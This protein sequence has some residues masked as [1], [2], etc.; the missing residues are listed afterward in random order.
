MS[1]TKP[2]STSTTQTTLQEA[3]LCVGPGIQGGQRAALVARPAPAGTG[4]R[5]VRRDFPAGRGLI[6]ARWYNVTGFELNTAIHNPYGATVTG[7]DPLLTA[8]RAYGV[9][10][11]LIEVIGPELPLLEYGPQAFIDLIESTGIARQNEPRR[12]FW[13]RQPVVVREGT[14]V[15][16]LLP[17]ADT[18]ISVELGGRNG[19]AQAV[20]ASLRLWEAPGAPPLPEPDGLPSRSIIA[21]V[22]G[23]EPATDAQVSTSMMRIGAPPPDAPWNNILMPGARKLVDCLSDLALAGAPIIGHYFGYNPSRRLNRVLLRTLFNRVDG[24]AYVS[25]GE[26][27]RL[28]TRQTTGRSRKRK[29]A[30]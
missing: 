27:G 14:D 16:M 13:I 8:L 7:I 4:I 17:A 23:H 12:A 26:A 20:I 30:S 22:G 3:L 18:R 29:D 2:Q 9:D 6:S 11:A 15:A 28:I 5:F 24:W 21:R 25:V 10:N 1:W 19:K